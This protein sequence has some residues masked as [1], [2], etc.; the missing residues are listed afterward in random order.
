MSEQDQSAAMKQAV[1]EAYK[2][3]HK[4]WLEA[5][6]AQLGRWTA[7]GLAAALLGMGAYAFLW[8]NGWHK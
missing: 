2:E 3:A 5:K 1:K 4:E 7:R 6:Y 8:M